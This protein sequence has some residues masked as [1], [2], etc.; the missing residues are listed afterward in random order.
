[1]SGRRLPSTLALGA[2][3]TTTQ[4][5]ILGSAALTLAATLDA[6]NGV[7][8]ANVVADTTLPFA[9]YA[10]ITP[11]VSIVEDNLDTA[12]LRTTYGSKLRRLEGK[13]RRSDTKAMR[14]VMHRLIDERKVKTKGQRR[15]MTYHP[16]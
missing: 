14:P 6:I 3:T 4:V 16:A 10:D 11:A 1:M 12:G 9:S 2:A 5:K 8:N 15:G 7:T 13:K